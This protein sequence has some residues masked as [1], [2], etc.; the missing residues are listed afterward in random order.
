MVRKTW[1]GWWLGL[2]VGL[3]S[4]VLAQV[5]SPIPLVELKENYPNPFYPSTTISFAIAPEAC[6]N[7]HQPTVSLRVYNVLV[8][9]VAVPTLLGETRDPLE[10]LKLRC[11]EHRAFWDG[12]YLDGEREA[13]PGVYYYQLTVDG[14]RYTRK[15]IVQRRVASTSSPNGTMS[16]AGSE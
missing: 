5:R 2:M 10:N 12:K 16:S 9:V 15:M 4:P 1:A 8:Q 14:Q 7:G 13:T 3:G 6:R 11:G